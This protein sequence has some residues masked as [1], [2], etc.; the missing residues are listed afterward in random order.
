M[1]QLT[2]LKR[3]HIPQEERTDFFVYIDEFQNFAT[4][5]FA[6]ILSEARKYRLNT[7]LAHQTISQ[8]EDK[9]LLK[10]ILANVGTVIS[11]RTS[12]PS[13]EDFI[14]PLF[15]PQVDKN[16]ISNLPSYNFYIK[17]NALNPQDAFTGMTQNFTIDSNKS[18]R[19]QV[20]RTSQVSYGEK[21]I[22]I[23]PEVKKEV[24]KKAKTQVKKQ[25]VSPAKVRSFV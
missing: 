23:P 8:I 25:A 7:I 4:M 21:P 14:L 6:Q 16:E 12:N 10:V 2:A 18:I 11:F 9:D 24:V 3:V 22:T 13:D 1:F 20:I 5:T 15:S 19:E 17:I